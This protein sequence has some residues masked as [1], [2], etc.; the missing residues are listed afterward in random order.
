MKVSE[1]ARELGC[2]YVYMK[3][4]YD[5][6]KRPSVD[7]AKEIEKKTEGKV[8]KENYCYSPKIIENERITL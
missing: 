8:K 6:K 5:G 2:T 1:F 7:L 3:K 4:I